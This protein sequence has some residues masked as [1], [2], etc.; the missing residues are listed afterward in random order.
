MKEYVFEKDKYYS[1]RSGAKIVKA[2]ESANI[3]IGVVV[4]SDTLGH[5]I[6][7]RSSA[8]DGSCFKEIDYRESTKIQEGKYYAM[9]G[10]TLVVKALESTNEGRFNGVVVETDVDERMLGYVCS[11]WN[12]NRYFIIDYTEDTVS[13]EF[14]PLY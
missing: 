14:F 7:H 4:V 12:S 2:T 5:P 3:L 11:G 10:R 9:S 8:W 6:G 1:A 13:N